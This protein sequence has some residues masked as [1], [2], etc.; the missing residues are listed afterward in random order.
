MKINKDKLFHLYMEEVDKI[1]EVCD[2]KTHFGPEEIVS[3]ISTIIEKNPDLI[4]VTE[5]VDNNTV[6]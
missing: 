2:W 5:C 6:L 3:I 4:E 1:S